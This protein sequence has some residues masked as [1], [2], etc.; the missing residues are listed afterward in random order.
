VPWTTGF[1][2]V[3]I[4]HPKCEVR[5]SLQWEGDLKDTYVERVIGMVGRLGHQN[6]LVRLIGMNMEEMDRSGWQ[7]GLSVHSNPLALGHDVAGFTV[8]AETSVS[9]ECSMTLYIP[10]GCAYLHLP[11]GRT[12][13]AQGSTA[14]MANT[15][16]HL[17]TFLSER[18]IN[19]MA[20]AHPRPP[21]LRMSESL[22]QKWRR[23]TATTRGHVPDAVCDALS[24]FHTCISYV[25][26]VLIS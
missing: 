23:C 11:K 2:G 14:R 8:L 10:G 3:S 1:I 25:N 12:R 26:R 5:R 7:N 16:D 9:I 22:Y 13:L 6:S 24:A 19:S 18:G 20:K 15:E 21:Q 17:I 4:N